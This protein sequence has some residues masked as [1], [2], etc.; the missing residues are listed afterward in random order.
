LKK[1]AQPLCLVPRKCRKPCPLDCV[2]SVRTRVRTNG[3][4]RKA[5]AHEHNG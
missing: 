2:Q 5:E 3:R 4:S 1:R